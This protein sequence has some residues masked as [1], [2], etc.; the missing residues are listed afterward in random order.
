MNKSG[1][2]PVIWPYGDAGF[3]C[4][5]EKNKYFLCIDFESD[6]FLPAG[7]KFI[8]IK[9]KIKLKNEQHDNQRSWRIYTI[10][11]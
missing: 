2:E 3:K 5:Y 10:P 9:T 11:F 8:K 4:S 1:N 7:N 6:A